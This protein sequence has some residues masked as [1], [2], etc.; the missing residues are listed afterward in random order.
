MSKWSHHLVT[1]SPQRTMQV[2]RNNWTMRL[3]LKTAR[4][5]GEI[6]ERPALKISTHHNPQF[7]KPPKNFFTFYVDIYTST[8]LYGHRTSQCILDAKNFTAGGF[9]GLNVKLFIHFG[10]PHSIHALEA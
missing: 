9:I 1:K 7:G 10:H 5:C 8:L 3:K 2:K 4:Q 6:Q